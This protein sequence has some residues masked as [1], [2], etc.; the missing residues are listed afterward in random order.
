M[1]EVIRWLKEMHVLLFDYDKGNKKNKQIQF[2]DLRKVS[3]II[4]HHLSVYKSYMADVRSICAF[5]NNNVN[6]SWTGMFLPKT[7]VNRWKSIKYEVLPDF[8][9][10][11]ITHTSDCTEQCPFNHL[12]Q[13]LNCAASDFFWRFKNLKIKE[14]CSFFSI[15][16]CCEKVESC[17]FCFASK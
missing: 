11:Q 5:V 8:F 4:S 2:R 14:K 16:I 17:T 15:T 10:M 6:I 9:S 12:E 7:V 3:R 13:V 1:V